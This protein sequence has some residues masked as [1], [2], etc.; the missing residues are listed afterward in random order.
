MAEG[1]V[2]GWLNSDD[3]YRPGTFKKAAVIFDENPKVDFIFSDCLL[4]DENERII[5]YQKGRD[6]NLFSVMHNRNFI[7]QPTV[8]FRKEILETTGYLNEQYHM[9]MDFDFW[10]RISKN[11]GMKYVDD[12][13]A[14]FREQ[15]NSKTST[16]AA[17]FKKESKHSFFENR[18]SVFSPYYFEAFIRP[19][20]WHLFFRNILVRRIFYKNQPIM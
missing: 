20:I 6:P 7:A 13:F 5:G 11:H 2:I 17:M 3:L 9:S 15:S 4:I 19:K 8:F 16:N 18:G 1:D 10:R 12:I 14:C